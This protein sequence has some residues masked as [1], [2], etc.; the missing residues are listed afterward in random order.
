MSPSEFG[1]GGFGGRLAQR[2]LHRLSPIIEIQPRRGKSEVRLLFFFVWSNF[3]AC[4]PC[5]QERGDRQLGGADLLFEPVKFSIQSIVPRR[6]RQNSENSAQAE[7][8][9]TPTLKRL[10]KIAIDSKTRDLWKRS[11][12]N[13]F[14]EGAFDSRVACVGEVAADQREL[15]E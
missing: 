4:W 15:L 1:G 3:R 13:V 6:V 2:G 5:R 14:G 8:T 10:A 7:I 9:V 12:Q 11:T